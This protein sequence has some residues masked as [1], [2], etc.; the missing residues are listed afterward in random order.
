M[1]IVENQSALEIQSV[2]EEADLP[3]S[4]D[5][6]KTINNPIGKEN[7]IILSAIRMAKSVI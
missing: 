3:P 5:K 1:M 7:A 2:R 4:L 6:D